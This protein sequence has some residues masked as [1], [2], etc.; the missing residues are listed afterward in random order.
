VPYLLT[1]LISQ[2]GNR[3]MP[4]FYL[5]A[6]GVLGLATV[7]TIRETRGVDLLRHDLEV[8]ANGRE[9]ARPQVSTTAAR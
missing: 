2:T 5:I 9:P 1:L 3:M 7:L 4:A 6:V 8:A